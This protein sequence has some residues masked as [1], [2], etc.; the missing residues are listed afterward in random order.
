MEIYKL[1]NSAVDFAS[2]WQKLGDK[3]IAFLTG[4]MSSFYDYVFPP[5]II[6]HKSTLL[7]LVIIIILICSCPR[8]ISSCLW[9]VEHTTLW[10]KVY[11]TPDC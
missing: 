10:D 3:D 7:A 6:L 1:A 4:I 11:L 5:V 8:V 2:S 9:R